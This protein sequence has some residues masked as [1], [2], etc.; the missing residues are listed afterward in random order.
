MV[1]AGK[2]AKKCVH[3]IYSNTHTDTHTYM[4]I[5]MIFDVFTNA[6]DNRMHRMW[7]SGGADF[8]HSDNNSAFN[9]NSNVDDDAVDVSGKWLAFAFAKCTQT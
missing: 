2:R 9:R 4:F 6:G 3:D 5:E 1:A 7:S 8:D